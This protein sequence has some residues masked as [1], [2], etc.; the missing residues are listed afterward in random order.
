MSFIASGT[1]RYNTRRML[2][3]FSLAQSKLLLAFF[4]AKAT[5]WMTNDKRTFDL[6]KVWVEFYPQRLKITQKYHFSNRNFNSILFVQNS[7]LLHVVGS[8]LIF[9]PCCW[10]K[11]SF[12]PLCFWGIHFT[13]YCRVKID[14]YPT[15]LGRNLYSLI[16]GTKKFVYPLLLGLPTKLY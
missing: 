14:F 2:S 11:K 15:F 7:F 3:N 9:T 5:W 12:L 16:L 1:T 8:K 6:E 13:P 10:A 4:T